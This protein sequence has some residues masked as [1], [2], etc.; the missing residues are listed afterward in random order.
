MSASDGIVIRNALESVDPADAQHFLINN[1]VRSIIE[2]LGCTREDAAKHLQ[3]L[4][5]AKKIRI[6]TTHWEDS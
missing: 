4:R 1:G 5:A 6:T 2:L 3:R